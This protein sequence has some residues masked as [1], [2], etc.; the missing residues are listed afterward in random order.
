MKLPWE[1]RIQILGEVV[2]HRLIHVVVP[3]V[4]FVIHKDLHLHHVTTHTCDPTLFKTGCG[5][6]SSGTDPK[7]TKKMSILRVSRQ[8][9]YEAHFLFWKTNTF[10]IK[11]AWSCYHFLSDGKVAK[12]IRMLYLNISMYAEYPF[13]IVLGKGLIIRP[14][15]EA[16]C[17]DLIISMVSLRELSIQ[18]RENAVITRLTEGMTVRWYDRHISHGL[19]MRGQEWAVLLGLTQFQ[20]S[21]LREVYVELAFTPVPSFT[22]ADKKTWCEN[23]RAFLLSTGEYEYFKRWTVRGSMGVEGEMNI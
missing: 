18:V 8:L 5:N 10:A 21:P 7:N 11:D 12:E 9:Y 2:G 19:Q 13:D 16:L 20:E 1:L 6:L 3:Y 17:R 4:P 22:S 14:W 15:S 23:L